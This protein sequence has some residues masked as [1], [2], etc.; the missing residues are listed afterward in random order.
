M[1]DEKFVIIGAL[2]N[3]MGSGTYVYNTLRGKTK[4]NRVTWF[5]WALA[6]LIAV[7][8]QWLEGVTWAALMTFMVGF[9]PFI[10]LLSSF[11]NRKA[12]WK[13]TKL[14][15]ICG[16]IS[17]SALIL[18]L[19]TG[20]GVVAIIF[21]IL[22]DLVAGIPTLIKAFNKPETEHYIVFRNGAISAG[23]TLLTIKEWG[24][25][26]YGFALYILLICL[27]LYIFIRF[28]VG[29]KYFKTDT[30]KEVA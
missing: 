8:A 17:I 19:V 3:M 6:P 20:Q 5:L 24:F 16:S 14:D 1:I 2:L 28:K 9:G 29:K 11:V 30:A 27:T 12:Y 7:S 22:A 4:P 13:I 21:S 15:I 10:I 26:N 23:I 25:V 18:W